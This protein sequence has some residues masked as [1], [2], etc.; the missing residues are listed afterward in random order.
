MEP[1]FEKKKHCLEMHHV[2]ANFPPKTLVALFWKSTQMIFVKY[3]LMIGQYQSKS[4][5]KVN[6]VKETLIHPNI[7]H[8]TPILAQTISSFCSRNP[9]SRI[10]LKF[11][12]MV[13]YYEKAEL[14]T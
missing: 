14:R 7:V 8:F 10:F 3:F 4:E 5:N 6:I 11:C 13:G 9:L 1:N 12:V 2:C